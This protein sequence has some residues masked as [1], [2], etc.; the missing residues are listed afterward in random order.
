MYIDNWM[1]LIIS[2]WKK[3]AKRNKNADI[4]C[5]MKKRENAIAVWSEALIQWFLH[6]LCVTII[7]DESIS[8][9]SFCGTVE[10]LY[11][12]NYSRMTHPMHF[13]GRSQTI[14][15]VWVSSQP[16]FQFYFWNCTFRGSAD[17]LRALA[18]RTCMQHNKTHLIHPTS[19]P[20][21]VPTLYKK[22]WR[23]ICHVFHSNKRRAPL[24]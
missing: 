15:C 3:I 18:Y 5:W 12:L 22:K 20:L 8:F 16:Y 17:A 9:K 11:I 21:Y 10:L 1:D 14:L 2:N 4:E 24:C 7:F 13:L 19:V 23:K 6:L